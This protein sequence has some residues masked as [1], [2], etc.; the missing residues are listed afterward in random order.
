MAYPKARITRSRSR[1]RSRS[2]NMR[3][4]HLVKSKKNHSKKYRGGDSALTADQVET[5]IR[6]TDPVNLTLRNGTIFATVSHYYNPSEK[7]INFLGESEPRE[8]PT[9]LGTSSGGAL[10]HFLYRSQDN[11]DFLVYYQPSREGK[12]TAYY[13]KQWMITYIGQMED[14]ENPMTSSRKNRDIL[15]D[16]RNRGE[17]Y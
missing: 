8:N 12:I 7:I 11:G 3:K 1:S 5:A 17:Y 14:M 16:I 15:R 13:L 10:V 9:F 2:R 4:K 6:N